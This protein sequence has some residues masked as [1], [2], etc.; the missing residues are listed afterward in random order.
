MPF[1]CFKNEGFDS[2]LEFFFSHISDIF[3]RRPHFGNCRHVFFYNYY[4]NNNITEEYSLYNICIRREY[5][6]L[7]MRTTLLVTLTPERWRGE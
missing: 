3:E 5:T 7:Y 1:L 6:N 4:K 2:R